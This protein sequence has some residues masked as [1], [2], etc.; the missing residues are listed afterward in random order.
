MKAT[1]IG[2]VLTV[3]S[4]YDFSGK[5]TMERIA[6]L[7]SKNLSK[8]LNFFLQN[9]FKTHFSLDNKGVRNDRIELR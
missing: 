7:E 8:K 9:L 3:Y 1:R 5:K 4:Q 6:E 2:K